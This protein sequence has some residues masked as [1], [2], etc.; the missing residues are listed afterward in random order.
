[1]RARWAASVI[2]DS[3]RSFGP[4]PARLLCPWDSPGKNTGVSGHALLQGLFPTQGLNPHLL[5]LLHWQAGSLALTLALKSGG[6][7]SPLRFLWV[8]WSREAVPR[9]VTLH[10]WANTPFFDYVLISVPS[11]YSCVLLKGIYTSLIFTHQV[12]EMKS[13]DLLVSWR[14][15]VIFLKQPEDW[16][17]KERF[18]GQFCHLCPLMPLITKIN[19]WFLTKHFPCIINYSVQLDMGICFLSLVSLSE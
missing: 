10:R 19:F 2:S 7:Y 11:F 17:Q 9:R 8:L 14:L 1:M 18:E 12:T 4:W 6:S 5:C 15:V 13:L 16:A 3:L